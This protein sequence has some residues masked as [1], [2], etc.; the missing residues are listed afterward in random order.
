MDKDTKLAARDAT[1][2]QQAER[3]RELEGMVNQWCSVVWRVAKHVGCLPSSFA[4]GNE[5]IVRAAEQQAEQLSAAKKDA[6]SK[7]ARIDELMLEYCPNEM[8][9]EQI[10][11]WEKH[12]VP[13]DS[14]I[15]AQEVKS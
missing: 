8:S 14:A 4:D 12:Q 5:H 9:P 10:E 2:A 3:I 1:I 15:T 11:E 13:D 6:D 7:Q